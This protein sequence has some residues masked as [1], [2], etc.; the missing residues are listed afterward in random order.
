VPPCSQG[1]R[2]RLAASGFWNRMLGGGNLAPVANGSPTPLGC[3]KW[4]TGVSTSLTLVR[5]SSTGGCRQ[6]AAKSRSG[7]LRA[8]SSIGRETAGCASQPAGSGGRPS[9]ATFLFSGPYLNVLGRSHDIAP[10]GRHLLVAGPE[11]TTT[12]HLVMVTNWLTRLPWEESPEVTGRSPPISLSPCPL[13]A[14]RWVVL[15][16]VFFTA[17]MLLQAARREAR[18][19]RLRAITPAGA[20]VSP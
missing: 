4:A 3:R 9:A 1:H 18:T 10:D 14:I 19:L 13:T 2:H 15:F 20:S 8:S 7:I 6:G 11:A 5:L 17:M 16:V 12:N